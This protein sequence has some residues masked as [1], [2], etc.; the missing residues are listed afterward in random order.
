VYIPRQIQYVYFLVINQ[1]LYFKPLTRWGK[2]IKC[3]Y[4]GSDRATKRKGNG[5]HHC[6]ACN[7]F[8]SVTFGTIFHDTKLPIQKWLLAI[9]IISNVKKFQACN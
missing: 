2:E 5:Y 7:K 6:G 3:T 9:S 4:C 1:E 8:L